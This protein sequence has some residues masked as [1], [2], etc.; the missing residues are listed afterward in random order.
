[1]TETIRD[2]DQNGKSPSSACEAQ[3]SPAIPD[4]S[5]RH[6]CVKCAIFDTA[7]LQAGSS[8]IHHE[9]RKHV[10]NVEEKNLQFEWGFG[11]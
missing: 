3:N 9:S 5:C 7:L 8:S 6:F 2:G 4:E 11:L 1:M 10:D